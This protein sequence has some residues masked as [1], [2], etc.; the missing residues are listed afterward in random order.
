MTKPHRRNGSRGFTL[1]ELIIFIV[2]VGAGLAGILAVST[3]VVKSSADPMVRKQAMAL[4][5][6]ILEE[7]VQKEY[8]DPDGVSG[9]TTRD[10]MDDVDD[11]NG[12]TK[13]LFT[14]WPAALGS[15]NVIIVVAPATLG[16][17]P[18]IAAKKVSVTVTGGDNVITMTGYRSNY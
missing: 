2:V 3:N 12:K 7:I 4:A 18:A 5:D 6:S 14:D 13:T 1:I 17:A 9:E 11:Y 10:T 16:T 15:Y 8:Q